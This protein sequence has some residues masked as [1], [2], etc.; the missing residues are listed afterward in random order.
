MYNDFM[1]EN[2]L[3]FYGS[4]CPHCMKM[5]K[6]LNKL[7]KEEG[8]KVSKLEIWHNEDNNKLCEKYDCES[9]P[10]GGVPFFIN[11]KT[12]KTLC[13]EVTYKEIKDWAS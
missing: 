8:I 1:N 12:G 13:G 6:L 2:L 5:E 3:F 7:T 10:C 4:E 11:Q 9:E